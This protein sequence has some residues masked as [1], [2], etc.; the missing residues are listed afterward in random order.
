MQRGAVYRPR[1]G[2]QCHCER[3]ALPQLTLQLTV[4]WSSS[5]PAC[6]PAH[7]KKNKCQPNFRKNVE[8]DPSTSCGPYHLPG[9]HSSSSIGD[10]AAEE[11]GALRLAAGEGER[12][13]A[14]RLAGQAT[15]EE[16]ESQPGLA[17][18]GIA[19]GAAADGGKWPSQHS[20]DTI[21]MAA[22]DRDGNIAAGCST[23][24]AIHKVG[25]CV[26]NGGAARQSVL[27]L[28]LTVPCS[29]AWFDE[30]HSSSHVWVHCTTPLQRN[31]S[32]SY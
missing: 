2:C 31:S 1:C 12:A 23:N 22:I 13:A 5:L 6:V 16:R 26:F 30:E 25:G 24:G 18:E 29:D 8:P 20:H 28:C 19:A 17:G 7:R 27:V 10:G 11:P 32:I 14:R 4:W 15:G 9:T 21:A 3:A